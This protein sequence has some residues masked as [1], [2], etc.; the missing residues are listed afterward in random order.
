MFANVFETPTPRQEDQCAML[1]ER[2]DRYDLEGV[3]R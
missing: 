2:A 1:H 3:E